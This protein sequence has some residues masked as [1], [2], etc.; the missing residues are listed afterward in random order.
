MLS[1]L[2]GLMRGLRSLD[3]KAFWS[4][5]HDWGSVEAV[6]WPRLHSSGSVE[7]LHWPWLHG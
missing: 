4:R 7:A 2:S 6:F 5:L 3:I 1:G